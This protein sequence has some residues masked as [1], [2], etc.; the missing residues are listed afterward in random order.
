MPKLMRK[1]TKLSKQRRHLTKMD[2][3]SFRVARK[4]KKIEGDSRTSGPR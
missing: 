2:K 3:G 1:G 4:V